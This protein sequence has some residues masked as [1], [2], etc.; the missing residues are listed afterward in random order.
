M[1]E[2]VKAEKNRT[3]PIEIYCATDIHYYV[4]VDGDPNNEEYS[5]GGNRLFYASG[6][7]MDRFVDVVNSNKPDFVFFKRGYNKLWGHTIVG[8]LYGQME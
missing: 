5:T 4:V 6:Q 2:L 1:Q 7:K 3:P 8:F